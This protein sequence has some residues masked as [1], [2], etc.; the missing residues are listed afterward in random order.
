MILIFVGGGDSGSPINT[1]GRFESSS[2]GTSSGVVK[3]RTGFESDICLLISDLV[4]SGLQV[5]IIAPSDIM[6]RLMRGK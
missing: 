3:A 5:V 4:L 1:I 6:E 2:F